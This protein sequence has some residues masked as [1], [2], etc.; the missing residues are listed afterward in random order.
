M[1]KPID[2][3]VIGVAI[4]V[5]RKH[6]NNHRTFICDIDNKTKPEDLNGTSLLSKVEIS[7]PGPS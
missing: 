7:H 6:K 2:Y 1:H 4:W 5:R 3:F